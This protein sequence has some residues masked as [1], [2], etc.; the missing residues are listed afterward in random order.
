MDLV[1]KFCA[2][3]LKWDENDC[4]EFNLQSEKYEKLYD[5]LHKTLNE[6][7]KKKLLALNWEQFMSCGQ[8]RD[9]GFAEGA[10][11]GF[12]LAMRLLIESLL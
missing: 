12:R 1:K 9:G 5:E 6:E 10:E 4:P 8:N 2:D 3:N 11:K 7:Q